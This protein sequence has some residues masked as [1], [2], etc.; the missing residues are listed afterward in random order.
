MH[1]THP[2][3]PGI[4]WD[5]DLETYLHQSTNNR[6]FPQVRSGWFYLNGQE[7]YLY[8]KE[9]YENI[10]VAY[11]L[12]NINLSTNPDL[13]LASRQAP[14][15]LDGEDLRYTRLTSNLT[16]FISVTPTAS[17]TNLL[18]IN[19]PG[20]LVSITN[21]SGV[22]LFSAPSTGHLS[23]RNYYYWDSSARVAWI[24][25]DTTDSLR[26]ETLYI[27]YLK[28]IPSLLQEE[29]LLVD[30]DGKIR[31]MFDRI[32]M[33]NGYPIIYV[34]GIGSISASGIDKNVITPSIPLA[35]GTRVAAKYYIDGSFGIFD[36]VTSV[37]NYVINTFRLKTDTAVFR[38]EQAQYYSPFDT[39][40]FDSSDLS[41]VQ[42]NPLHSGIESGFLYLGNPRHPAE[43]LKELNI[44]VSPIRVSAKQREP[45]RI[46]VTALD[47]SN[48]PLPKVNVSTWITNDSDPST[49]YTPIPLDIDTPIGGATDFSGKRHFM[50]SS[51][52]Q[53]V[54][55][56]TVYASAMNASGSIFIASHPLT[57]AESLMY[58]DIVN[59]SKVSL[60]LNPNKGSDG[61]SDLYI[62]L[63]T[64]YG[65]PMIPNL[66]VSIHCEKGRLY[67][68][69]SST[70]S[71]SNIG[72][73]DLEIGFTNTNISGLRVTTCRYSRIAGDRITAWPTS[74][75]DSADPSNWVETSYA[76]EC[77]PLEIES[78]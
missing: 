14:I 32:A 71:G 49:I 38:W 64:Q 29:V 10:T 78:E 27:T 21:S 67:Y 37:N 23:E 26:L 22:D 72:T 46:V 62:Y 43:D 20:E 39:G 61:L 53:L 24:S 28:D 74:N 75:K 8:A 16:A 11:G 34:P 73:Q 4:G 31:T 25:R 65:T 59:T 45:V 69:S 50:W 13:R 17:G 68:S 48:V 41:Y 5:T 56:Y 51:R 35:E 9:G 36:D 66:K 3:S 77:T 60:Y 76:F 6:W 7:D 58:T 57:L 30:S 18:F 70:A 2:V 55:T 15:I 54:G 63:T 52:P 19:V 12:S 44:K 1:N 47:T 40:V 42:L 33:W